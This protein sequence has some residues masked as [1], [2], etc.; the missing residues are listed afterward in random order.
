MDHAKVFSNQ[1]A[2]NI[3]YATVKLRSREFAGAYKSIIESIGINPS[4]PQPHNLLGIWFELHG[5]GDKARRHY[6]A[7]Y[8]LDPTFKAACNN[9][10]R[11]SSMSCF[12]T[13]YDFGDETEEENIY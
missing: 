6:R 8:A 3:Q 11:I 7:A 5:D 12:R 9:L 10:A 4:A 13:P 2:Q 1:F